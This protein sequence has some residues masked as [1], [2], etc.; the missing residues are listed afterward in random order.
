MTTQTI[1]DNTAI[2]ARGCAEPDGWSTVH[3][4]AWLGMLQTYRQLT[5]DLDAEL[6]V[7]HGLTLSG[8]ELLSRLAA[9]DERRAHL[10]TLAE[11]IGLS[12]SGVSR[13][14][15]TLA[16]AG[17]VERQTCPS[18]GRAINV[19]LTEAGVRLVREAQA[20]HFAGVQDRF[21]RHIGPDELQTLAAVFGRFAPDAASTCES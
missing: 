5:R 9:I 14:V 16:L 4:G 1:H 18:D 13:L 19:W 12:V 2:L 10:S 17:L 8:L 20:T 11:H 15:D 7:R 3:T 6:E 21:F